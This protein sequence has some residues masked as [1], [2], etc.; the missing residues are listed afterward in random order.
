MLFIGVLNKTYQ[1]R[2][3][4]C[5]FNP[6]YADVIAG[7]ER[8]ANTFSRYTNPLRLL[9]SMSYVKRLLIAN[10]MSFN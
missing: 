5:L 3:F 9:S 8:G 4:I 6:A 7:W 1:L 2:V 10:P